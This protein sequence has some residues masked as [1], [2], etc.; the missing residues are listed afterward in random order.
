MK[1]ALLLLLVVLVAVAGGVV[2]SRWYLGETA[3]QSRGE[4][5]LFGNVDIRTVQLA[6]NGEERIAELLVEE[7]DRV[8]AGQL[9]GRLRSARLEARLV[10]AKA[11]AAAQEE[12]VR[13][14]E[15]GTRPEAIE[16][17]RAELAAAEA[18]VR[19]AALRVARLEEVAAASGTS[20]QEVDDA[21]AVLDVERANL[22]VRQQALELAVKG[23]RT[24]DIEE[25]RRL[26]E[27][28]EAEVA[29]LE[30]Q[31]AESELHAPFAGVVQSRLLEP[32]AMVTPAKAVFTLARSDPKWIRVYVPQPD[33]GRIAEGM[34]ARIRSDSFPDRT[35]EGWVGFISPV[36]EFTPKAV[37]TTDLRTKL[38]YEVRVFVHDQRNEL[39]LGQPVTATII[40]AK[41]A[42]SGDAGQQE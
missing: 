21:Q 2:G 30:V 13:R 20:P 35:F 15:S 32:G 17:A 7:G 40:T 36:A 24:E 31:L 4:L 9:L 37:E 23:P 38:V 34:P 25:A 6:F 22:G 1:R 8:E 39:R 14:L 16:Q 28:A 29:L 42:T 10:A 11:R 18:R 3:L 33:L 19:A 26:R 41:P 5:Q 12:V 27:A